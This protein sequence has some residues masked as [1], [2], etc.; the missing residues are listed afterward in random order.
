[1]KK[2]FVLPMVAAALALS[3]CGKNLGKEVNESEFDAKVAQMKEM[4]SAPKRIAAKGKV[5]TKEDKQDVNLDLTL[6]EFEKDPV[7]QVVE[8]LVMTYSI[9]FV[10]NMSKDSVFKRS[11]YIDEKADTVGIAFSGSQKQSAAG[12]SIEASVE[13]KF[14]WNC[15]GLATYI[16]LD[17]KMSA[18][19]GGES[20]SEK[21]F[22]ELD[23]IYTF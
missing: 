14:A 7:G 22:M 18:S 16:L 17:T 12:Y 5:E 2:L 8:E 6:D 23:I 13:G 11:F 1:M 21:G 4:P 19:G 15:Y 3:G 10:K 9:E 20:E